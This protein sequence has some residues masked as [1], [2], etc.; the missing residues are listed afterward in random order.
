MKE[1]QI[2]GL[3]VGSKEYFDSTPDVHKIEDDLDKGA[4][5]NY[6]MSADNIIRFRQEIASGRAGTQVAYMT[7]YL[8]SIERKS[9]AFFDGIEGRPAVGRIAQSN[10]YQIKG[11]PGS[12]QV[13]IR[14]EGLDELED[15]LQP[16]TNITGSGILGLIQKG[17]DNIVQKKLPQLTVGQ[18]SHATGENRQIMGG[19]DLETLE[20]DRV[21][22]ENRRYL[23]ERG[24]AHTSNMVMVR[25]IAEKHGGQVSWRFN[26]AIVHMPGHLSV[27]VVNGPIVNDRMLVDVEFFSEYFGIQALHEPGDRFESLLEAV[28]AWALTYHPRSGPA[29]NFP[30]GSEF[31]AYIFSEGCG[32]VFGRPWAF[33]GENFTIPRFPFNNPV[34][35]VHTHPRN[36]DGTGVRWVGNEFSSADAQVTNFLD[37]PSFLVSPEGKIWI[38]E[39][40]KNGRDEGKL[41][42]ENIFG[43]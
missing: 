27:E 11:Q 18:N 20:N 3:F 13:R 33:R 12:P 8:D 35:W 1:F 36:A 42:I 38:W 32:Y 7:T 19:L 16:L 9:E 2:D 21:S 22:L 39:L 25:P 41:E 15:A 37:I 34:A 5:G 29:M 14:L 40:G 43:R 17:V 31:G 6:Y 4:R 26:T 10:S 24:R 23:V 30:V 28:H